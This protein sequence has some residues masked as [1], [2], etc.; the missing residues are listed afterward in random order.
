MLFVRRLIVYGLLFIVMMQ[1]ASCSPGVLRHA[2]AYFDTNPPLGD[3]PFIPSGKD[4][5]TTSYKTALRRFP[6]LDSC[7][8]SWGERPL[9]DTF[10]EET[11]LKNFAWSRIHDPFEAEVCLFRVLNRIG[12]YPDA[13][14]WFT[15]QGFS[16]RIYLPGEIPHNDMYRI[17]A[18]WL[19]PASGRRFY[20]ESLLA[21]LMPSIA[22]SMGV[23]AYWAPGTGQ[24][25]KVSL[26]FNTL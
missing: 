26:E 23:N 4:G 8:F 20:G 9:W 12:N 15:A 24:L 19:I 16:S 21:R 10:P 3:P 6:D 25:T 17:H 13:D 14:R 2:I 11:V 18:V 22:Y 7:L 1:L 5:M